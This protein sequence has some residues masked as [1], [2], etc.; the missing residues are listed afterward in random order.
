MSPAHRLTAIIF[1]RDGEECV[2]CCA[3]PSKSVQ[4]SVDHV[5]PRAAFERGLLSGDP[6]DPSNLVTAC[7]WCN[8][9]KRDMSLRVFAL[10]LIDGHGWTEDDAK[11]M[12]ARVKAAVSRKV[13]K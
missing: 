13:Q 1:A 5:N 6:D 10:Y 7:S 4:L 8:S 2:Y 9:A 3:L 12:I 11:A